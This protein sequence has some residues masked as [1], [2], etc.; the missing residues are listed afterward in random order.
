MYL[1]EPKFLHITPAKKK[2]TYPSS[3]YIPNSAMMASLGVGIKCLALGRALVATGVMISLRVFMTSKCFELV[4][5]ENPT[6]ARD[7]TLR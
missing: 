6:R 4:Q 7:L 5:D 2:K 1:Y 3:Q